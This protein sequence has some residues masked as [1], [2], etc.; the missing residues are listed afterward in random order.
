LDPVQSEE[1][2]PVRHGMIDVVAHDPKSDQ[3]V[4][5]MN[6]PER[7]TGAT[8]QLFHLQERFNTY[9]SFLLDGE[10]TETHPELAQKVARIELRCA[11]MPDAHAIDLLGQIR[12]QLSLQ[13]IDLQVIV[14][15]GA[16]TS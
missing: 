12:D 15:G 4:L 2:Y 3:V 14:R 16:A 11:H 9:V 6:Q 1:E 10:L 7:W 13:E 5:V 8:E